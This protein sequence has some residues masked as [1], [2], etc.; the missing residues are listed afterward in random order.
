VCAYEHISLSGSTIK[1]GQ[2]KEPQTAG[3]A[4]A[5]EAQTAAR[6]LKGTAKTVY[7]ISVIDR[8]SD[9]L[10]CKAW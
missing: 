6:Q 9:A 4:V 3:Q 5:N 1:A 10:I 8:I 7:V 2:T